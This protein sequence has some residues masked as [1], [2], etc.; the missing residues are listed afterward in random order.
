MTILV[1]GGCGFIGSNFII[2]H[3]DKS[4]EDIINL[5]ALTYAGNIRTLQGMSRSMGRKYQFIHG[6]INDT[7]TVNRIIN[8]CRPRAIFNFAAESHVDNSIHDS[9][10]FVE[11]NVLGTVKLLEAVRRSERQIRFIHISTDE[12]YGS[13][14][15]T[16]DAFRPADP[17]DPRSP[18]SASKAASDHFV[19]AYHHTYGLDCVLTNCS[20]NYGPY[21]HAEKLIPTIIRK[22]MNDERVPIYGTGMNIRDWIYVKDHCEGIRLAESMGLSGK[23]Y[24]FGGGNQINNLELAKWILELMGKSI[25]LI[26]FV[27]DRKGHDFRYDIDNSAT[28]EEIFWTPKTDLENGL[29][30]TIEWYTKNMEWVNSCRRNH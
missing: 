8:Q 16:D 6:S 28:T 24:L 10:P 12:V 13:L 4:D 17:Y 19:M 30:S 21:Q 5:D 11:T 14:N 29:K 18:Y 27:D 25:D 15:P 3:L 20:N 2:N 23:K 9:L 22:A 26:E 7:D 1:T